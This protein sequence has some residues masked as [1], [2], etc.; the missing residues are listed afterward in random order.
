M[1]NLGNRENT[2]DRMAKRRLARSKNCENFIFVPRCRDQ[3]WKIF[4]ANLT[5]KN[6]CKEFPLIFLSVIGPTWISRTGPITIQYFKPGLG[7]IKWDFRL[8]VKRPTN[9]PVK[10]GPFRRYSFFVFFG[11]LAHRMQPT[12]DFW[13]YLIGV[14]M[15]VIIDKFSFCWISDLHAKPIFEMSFWPSLNIE[16]K[17]WDVS[18]T[19]LNLKRVPKRVPS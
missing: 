9:R 13:N 7:R 10:T 4:I 2:H 5:T 16:I 1:I 3:Q 6:W 19:N 15:N 12:L 11:S 18:K 17:C 8:P 14:L